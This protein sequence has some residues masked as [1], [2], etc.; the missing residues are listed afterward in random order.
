M[1]HLDQEEKGLRLYTCLPGFGSSSTRAEIGAGILAIAAQDPTHIGSDSQSFIDKG[2]WV[3]S[4][5]KQGEKP[6]KPWGS[7]KDGDLWQMFYEFAQAKGE[8]SIKLSKVQGHATD[9]Q[10]SS[11]KV[12]KEDKLG[13]DKAD[14][15]AKKGIGLHGE[16][17]VKAANWYNGRHAKYIR[18]IR[19]IHNH[20][21]EGTVLSNQIIQSKQKQEALARGWGSK[22][23]A[24]QKWAIYHSKPKQNCA[25]SSTPEKDGSEESGGQESAWQKI[26][27]SEKPIGAKKGK[28]KVHN[29][30]V[31]AKEFLRRCEFKVV[32][33]DVF[34]TTWLELFTLYRKLGLPNPLN[35]K[36]GA[37]ARP[38]VRAQVHRFKG[39][40]RQAARLHVDSDVHKSFFKVGKKKGYALVRLGISSHM[41]HIAC[42]VKLSPEAARLVDQEI[43]VLN[44]NTKKL[45]GNTVK[46]G[47]EIK[48]NKLIL[49][50]KT[51]W[52]SRIS[53]FESDEKLKFQE[54]SFPEA[55]EEQTPDR[56]SGEKAGRKRVR[57]CASAAL[58]PEHDFVQ[59]VVNRTC[60]KPRTDAAQNGQ[61]ILR[62]GMLKG[63]LKERF[64][65]LCTA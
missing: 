40:I 10:V 65:Y 53:P 4:L 13:N 12:K 56:G 33:G 7:H 37:K 62:I 24:K 2:N 19:D 63:R 41:P 1:A 11:G 5:I 57:P 55:E 31:H 21:I 42:Q 39:W 43:L 46:N 9:Q 30:L 34:G 20:L 38:N 45:L 60:K 25:S 17:V 18:L 35:D 51:A 52:S 3:L 27:I 23:K 15:A 22:A 28:A 58:P 61:A 16:V 44:G 48:D 6:R 54:Q 8:Q 59:P 47:T 29:Q 49:R 50:N 36:K 64:A 14:E 32:E 26:R